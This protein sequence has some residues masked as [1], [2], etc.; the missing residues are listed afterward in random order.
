MAQTNLAVVADFES[1]DGNLLSLLRGASS[2]IANA[3]TF[4][5]ILEAKDKASIVKDAAKRAASI[6]RAHGGMVSLSYRLKADALA[7]EH[8]AACRLADEY[9]AAQER[10]EIKSNGGARNFTVPNENSE[11]PNAADIGLSRKTVFE[12]RQIRDAEK[13]DPGIIQRTLARLLRP[14]RRD[15]PAGDVPRRS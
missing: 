11:L 2:A 14:G 13:A 3:V 5:E 8:Q 7:I 6:A 4:A 15:L 9:D 12:A 10:G 1:G